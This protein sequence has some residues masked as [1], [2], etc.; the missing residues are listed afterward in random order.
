V[1]LDRDAER[2]RLE[3]VAADRWYERGANGAM[4][5]YCAA[6]F[7]RHCAEGAASSS[8]RRRGS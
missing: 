3:E 1:S 4:I 7:E 6:L 8:A 5:R 2:T